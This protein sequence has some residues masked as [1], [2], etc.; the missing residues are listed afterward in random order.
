MIPPGGEDYFQTS[1]RG[2]IGFG[3]RYAPKSMGL[4]NPPPQGAG[5]G[6]IDWQGWDK[7]G[8]HPLA[9][10]QGQAVRPYDPHPVSRGD[11]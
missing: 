1:V 8:A 10:T 9:S 11:G 7:L 3:V 6:R 5:L 4:L 2:T